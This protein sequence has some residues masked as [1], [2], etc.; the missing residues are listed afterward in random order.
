MDAAIG[1]GVDV[2]SISF[3]GASVPF[4]RD[5]LAISAFKA[6]QKGIFVSCSVGNYG[7]FNGTLSNEVPWVLTVWASTIDRRIRTIVYLGNKK[8]LDGESLYQPK[9]FHQKLMP[10]VS[11]CM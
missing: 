3:G 6:I 11:Y 9:S 2:L 5:S 8:L 10:L 1:D 4:Y 7:P